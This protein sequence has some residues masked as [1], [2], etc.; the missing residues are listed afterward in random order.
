MRTIAVID[1]PAV[2]RKVLQH[3]LLWNPKPNHPEHPARDPSCPANTTIPLTYH[4]VPD[5]A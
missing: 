3:L 1:D 2:I 5:I 4:P